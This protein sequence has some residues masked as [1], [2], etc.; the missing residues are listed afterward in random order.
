MTTLVVVD[1]HPLFRKGLVALLEASGFDVVAEAASAAEAVE[2]VMSHRPD[3]VLIDLGLPDRSGL[4][5]TEQLSAA[6]PETRFVV[7]TM[8]D[9]A[10]TV[11]RALEAGATAYVT[12][13]ASPD[14]VVAAVQAVLMGAQWLDSGVPRPLL[15]SGTA[16]RAAVESLPGLTPRERSIAELIGKGLP[17]EAIAERLGVSRKT[18]ANYVSSVLLKL[19]AEDRPDAIRIVRRA[20]DR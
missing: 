17:N 16:T 18:V 5:A 3:A 14:H 2:T 4:A 10:D 6:L 7:I 1:D 11:R 12:K 8:Y 9:D 13:D 20:T 15:D 19:G